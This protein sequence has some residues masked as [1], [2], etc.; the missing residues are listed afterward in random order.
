MPILTISH[1]TSYAYR[2]PVAFGEHRIFVR[3]RESY[4]QRL[5]ESR[6][7]IFPE[8]SE[9]RWLHD[10]FGN[11]VAIARFNKR[12]TS[13]CFNSWVK[14][15]HS[16]VQTEEVALEEYAQ[17]YPFSYSSENMADLLRSIER[18]Y[19]DPARALDTWVSQFVKE[20]EK[21]ETVAMLSDLTATIR[22]EFTYLPR[23]EKGTQSPV[24]TLQRRQGT[25]R[26]F[27]VLMMEAA[28]TL[29]LAS[30]FVSGYLYNPAGEEGRV[31]GGS[32]H[33][34]V[35]IFLPGSGWV[36]FDPTNGIVGNA[37]L[38]RVAVARDPCQAVP[39]SGTFSGFP[40]SDLGM[41]VAVEVH[42]DQPDLSAEGSPSLSKRG[43][44][45]C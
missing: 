32:T 26:D 30:R 14:M 15:E 43:Y 22:R 40:S 33:A 13:L 9:L 19:P 3:P 28:R 36:E 44:G 6:L 4:D 17:L 24:E 8:P 25:C 38:I 2:Q 5:I 29:G 18:Q 11:S 10:V 21:T 45:T 35:R 41:T 39:I 12:S 31:G 20:G 42:L 27:A 1:I 7:D 23:A 34:W 16:P 37:G